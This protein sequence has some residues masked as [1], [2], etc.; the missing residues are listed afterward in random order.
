MNTVLEILEK[1]TD[2]LARH[3]VENPRLEAEWLV[4][5]ELG[6]R[7]LDLYL[8]FERPLGEDVLAAL[9][10]RLKRRAAREPLA[11]ILGTCHFRDLDLEA[12]PDALIPRPETEDLVDQVADRLPSPPATILDLGTGSGALAL[13][14]A[15]RYPGAAVAAAERSPGALALARRNGERTGH[16]VEWIE[17]DWFDALKGRRFDLIVANPPYL[18]GEEWATAQPEVRDHEPRE[19]LVA[20]DGGLAD[21]RTILGEAPQHLNPG[22]LLALETGIGHHPALESLAPAAG[23][24]R[25]ESLRDVHR[26]PRFFLAWMNR[27]A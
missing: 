17:S 24:S 1:S 9:R 8:Q 21:L 11:H 26:R 16:T 14:L 18:T 6:L 12:G 7:R 13:A 23:Y 22:G 25:T 19:A 3:G 5:A 10:P 4:G 15:G 2:F 20:G 27:P